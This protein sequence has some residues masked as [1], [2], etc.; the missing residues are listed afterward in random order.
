MSRHAQEQTS[1]G[2]EGLR[3]DDHDADYARDDFLRCLEVWGGNSE[4]TDRISVP[5]IDAV[6]YSRPHNGDATG[7]DLYYVSLCGSGNISRFAV[8]DVSGHGA[9]ADHF[10]TSLKKLIRKHIN[11]PNQAKF[12]RAL[13]AEF[14]RISEEGR[15]ATAVLMTYYAPTDH[16]IVS[17]AGH[18]RPLFYRASIGEWMHLGPEMPMDLLASDASE[19][20]VRNLPLGV[21]EP[22]DYEQFALRLDVG[23]LVVVYTDS[24]LEAAPPGGEQLGEHGLLKLA[25]EIDPNEP[26]HFVDRFVSLVRE[27]QRVTDFQDDA[28]VMMLHAN[29]ADPARPSL[30]EAMGMLGRLIGVVPVV[31]KPSGA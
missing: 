1:D 3:P 6:V 2:A 25:G 7:G 17:N 27:R 19:V 12:T 31:R 26:E 28:T 10:A 11:T 29:N 22:T 23:D 9:G 18:P 4:A 24:I 16:L 13:N 30:K 20:G 21:V 14:N 8:A 15:F 5:G